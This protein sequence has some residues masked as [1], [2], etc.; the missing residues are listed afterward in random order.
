MN[1]AAGHGGAEKRVSCTE[2]GARSVTGHTTAAFTVQCS[3]WQLWREGAEPERNVHGYKLENN[4]WELKN[5]A[6][7]SKK[8]QRKRKD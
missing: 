4:H 8:S 2:E 7:Y 1:A 6:V 3:Q 5:Q